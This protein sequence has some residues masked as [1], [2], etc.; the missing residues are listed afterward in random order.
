MDLRQR[1]SAARRR[2]AKANV[3]W[4]TNAYGSALW[5]VYFAHATL[6]V[7]DAL[8]IGSIAAVFVADRVEPKH[9]VDVEDAAGDEYFL[10]LVWVA[11]YAI[12]V[13]GPRV[14]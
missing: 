5:A 4:D 1:P 9:Y 3:R 12:V 14:L 6:M 10:S 2:I 13:L 8:E 11:L 7:T